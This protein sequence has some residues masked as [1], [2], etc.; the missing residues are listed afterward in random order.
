M[1]QRGRLILVMLHSGRMLA[2]SVNVLFS[3]AVE[4]SVFLHLVNW[5]PKGI[6]VAMIG[7]K[8]LAFD[9]LAG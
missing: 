6:S 9:R 8:L 4:D 7:K 1:G 5:S 2:F 3:C